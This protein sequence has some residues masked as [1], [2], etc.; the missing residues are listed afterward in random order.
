MTPRLVLGVNL[1][2]VKQPVVRVIPA[3]V[4]ICSGEALAKS[5][6]LMPVCGH[7]KGSIYRFLILK[8]ESYTATF[9]FYMYQMLP[10]CLSCYPLSIALGLTLIRHP[11][12]K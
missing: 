5:L 11:Q 8:N 10:L 12:P 4:Y 3:L 9:G 6:E 1:C 7:H 2:N